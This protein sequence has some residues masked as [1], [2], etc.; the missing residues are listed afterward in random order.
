MKL[1]IEKEADALYLS[2]DDSAIVESEE[3]SPGVVLDYNEA[4]Q[5][6]GIELLH[7]S[8]QFP[9][10]YDDDVI[11]T[12]S[13]PITLS[14]LQRQ[15]LDGL[16][17]VETEEYR[18]GDWYLGALYALE[19]P[20][21]PDR[22]SQA[23]QSL[24]ELVEKLP[25]VLRQGD[26]DFYMSGSDF[27][28]MRE[29]IFKRLEKAK[30]RY[31]K[32]FKGK[33]I[34]PHLDKTLRKIYRYVELNKKPTRKDQIQIAIRNIDP[35]ADQMGS[36]IQDRKRDQFHTLWKQLEDFAHHG[37]S[38]QKNEQEFSKCVAILE[39][40]VYDLLAPVTAQDQEEIQSILDRTE[41]ST[42]DAES[43]YKLITK[44]GA[45][46]VFFFS[47]STD[48]WW[49][50]FLEEKGFF[51]RPPNTKSLS[52]G[53]IQYPFWPEL[54]YLKN[55][56]KDDPEEVI[57]LVLQLPE[58]DNPRVYDSILEIA[59]ELAGEQ[60][61]RL[62]PKMLEYAKLEHQFLA[63]KYPK[64]LAHWTTKDQTEA[65]LELVEILL[66][67]YPDEKAEDKRARRRS[68]PK[69]WTTSLD[70]RLRFDEWEFNEILEKG[71]R[72]LAERDP[73][74]TARIL[75]DATASMIPLRFHQDE[76]T[77]IGSNDNS[78]FWC[79][80]VNVSLKDYQNPDEALVHE[81]TFACEQVYEKARESVAVLDQALRKKHWYIFTRIRQHL[82]ALHSNEQT[83]PWIR[84]M[85]L[86]HQD[87]D[88]WHH[89][90]EFQRMIRLA[91][92]NFGSDLLS[93][94]E[95]KQ[96]FDAILSGPS[97]PNYR[98]RMGDRFTEEGFN[99]RK[100]GFH[101]AQLTPF[102]PLLIG[103]YGEYFKELNAEE[104]RPVTDDDY[105]PF[106]SE[107]AKFIQ[108]R[109]PKSIEEL[110]KWS[111]EDL[112]SFLIEWENP[113]HDP[114]EWSIDINFA[115]LAQEFQSIFKENIM[116]EELRLQFWMKN[117]EL[118]GR[119]IYVR[120]M[121]S[122]IHEQVESKQFDKLDQW[123]DFCEWVL[124]HPDQPKKEGVNSSD[125]SKEGPDWQSSRRA[126]GDFVGMCLRKEISVPIKRRNGLVSLLDMLCTQYDRGLDEDEPVVL[127]RDD[128]FTEA[129]NNTRSRALENLV[130]FGLWVRR[131]D[132]N[133]DVPEIKAILDKRLSSQA[134]H[135]LT[136]PEHAMLGRLY[137]WIFSL[138][139]KWAIARKS[140]FFPKNKM[141]AWREAFGNFLRHS[142]PYRPIYN[143]LSD[144]FEF[145]L[146]HLDYLKHQMDFD[147]KSAQDFLGQHL[148][149]YYL[150]KVYRLKGDESLL[151]R[152]YQKTE[153]DRN[154]WAT[155]FGHVGRLLGNTN[156][157]DRGL[158]ERIFTFFEW[159]LEEGEPS[160][161]QKFVNWLE[162]DCLEAEWRLNAYSRILDFLPN[163]NADQW[164]D[165]SGHI[166]F[167]AIPKMREMLP[168]V[169]GGVV[170][171]FAKLID[172]MPKSG[173]PYL[174]TDDAKAILKAG[175]DHE[176]KDVR[177]K[178]RE[179]QDNLLRRGYFSVKDLDN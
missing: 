169:C 53:R 38:T 18:L 162:A 171:C 173:V 20:Y 5:V 8:K 46:Y 125:T 34:D 94:T 175:L 164:T 36:D 77:K 32:V 136:L 24:R 144:N 3:V 41:P 140:A 90:F 54:Q 170:E 47:N 65:A 52:E 179:T 138:D 159:R 33:E 118:V 126:V 156:Q 74:R 141:R 28:R 122:A 107:G 79:P 63:H 67:F 100:R 14:T 135:P 19:N 76:L 110:K 82:F 60:S 91:C 2:L 56:C 146:D 96:I 108:N 22:I 43:L 119:P 142:H 12:Q 88:K 62:K 167:H 113:H 116:P 174:R 78:V 83:K 101:L 102:T 73:Y 75:I 151:E 1:H 128:Q 161:L 57:Q 93:K 117:R 68:H 42:D 139:E 145:S 58:V 158:K 85:I 97:E 44:K 9:N 123:F 111:D 87:Y 35:M 30:N 129:I 7:L 104:E 92:E 71:V 6:A 84:E 49:I 130:D 168:M 55:V 89:H 152:F 120:A 39:Q 11:G 124:S 172:S 31:G 99:A 50:P 177:E 69:D 23:A 132:G 153:N 131:H 105:M 80:R 10:L 143:E 27:Q 16:R 165:Q 106:R 40:I 21:N 17:R 115:G 51:R 147:K 109:S 48:S 98:E 133:A 72:S 103:K 150:W 148:F 134:K 64:L 149:H 29:G 81:L 61:A 176:D 26:I 4:N 114:D 45:N 86:A 155:L 15:V 163:L 70:P 121:V 137:R 37:S 157:L 13:K 160:E 178:A 166:S 25:R 66:Q 59:L 127:D 154:Y 95:K 112:L